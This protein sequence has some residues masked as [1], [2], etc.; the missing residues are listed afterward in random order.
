MMSLLL[1]RLS[2]S[3]A[4]FA[5]FAP[6]DFPVFVWRQQHKGAELPAELIQ[7]F[8]GTNVERAGAAEWVFEQ[9]L[10]FYVGH[11]P[12][13]DELHL[14]R[15]PEYQSRFDEW[16]RTRDPKLLVRRPCLTEEA[17]RAAL[18][19]QLE[20][21]LAAR[22][23]RHGIGISLG[24]EVSLTPWGDP[25]DLCRSKTCE[26]AWLAWC[27]A[28]GL[29]YRTAPTTDELRLAVGD[30]DFSLL[31]AWLARRRFHQDVV[32][33]LLRELA[34]RA[35]VLAPGVRVGLLG[36]GGQTAF[37]GVAIE[38]ALEF[39]DFVEP[40][41]VDATREL[42]RSYE[43]P[44]QQTFATLFLNDE[45]S[46]GVAGATQRAWEHVL[47]GGDG[48]ILWS[49]KLLAQLPK[50]RTRMSAV[51]RSIRHLRELAPEL[52]SPEWG[53][54]SHIALLHSPDSVAFTWLMD[55]L[56]DGPTWPNRLAGYQREHGSRERSLQAWL[57]LSE[58][59]GLLPGV[60]SLRNLGAETQQRFQLLVSSHLGILDDDEVERLEAYLEA[61]GLLV[62]EGSFGRFDSTGVERGEDLFERLHSRHPKAVER[63][64][65]SIPEYTERRVNSDD[66]RADR[67]RKQILRLLESDPSQR[68]FRIR[69]QPPGTPWLTEAI[70]LRAGN[71][72]LCMAVPNATSPE[73]RAALRS[74][75]TY[76]EVPGSYR[77][78]WLLPKEGH[79]QKIQVAAGEPLCF[80]LV[81]VG[82]EP[83]DD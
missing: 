47:R 61:G 1:S 66:Q 10:D 83:E 37:G 50:Y 70:P 21:S 7:P 44:G 48:L 35:R 27:E 8:G 75:R 71:G 26:A 33:G 11:A 56:L 82:A 54:P 30:D 80:R 16:Y 17:T 2:V 31:G 62:V 19:D 24:D 49:D 55:A 45:E 4:L 52:D 51:V 40:Y 79:S 39:L 65:A 38:R 60:V 5:S 72:W 14:R 32:L 28:E 63:A 6:Q 3:V 42:A 78:E 15:T 81:K 67:D 73:E 29:E 76:V 69:S 23:G 13:R 77:V 34:A 20:L 22:E 18:F 53:A 46:G 25:L 74:Q 64:S 43:R 57:R 41:P 36:I 58:D 59:L 68:L 12:G 9:Q